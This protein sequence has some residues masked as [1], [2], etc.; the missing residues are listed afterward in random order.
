MINHNP[1]RKPCTLNPD[2]LSGSFGA[3]MPGLLLAAVCVGIVVQ[4]SE[5]GSYGLGTRVYGLGCRG[6]GF[7]E[8]MQRLREKILQHLVLPKHCS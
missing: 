7:R 5:F 2:T 3:G 8:S 1:K 4:G 6:L